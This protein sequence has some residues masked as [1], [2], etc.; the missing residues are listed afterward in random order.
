MDLLIQ[1]N[2]NIDKNYLDQLDRMESMPLS[3]ELFKNTST[4]YDIPIKA[5]IYRNNNGTGNISMGQVYQLVNYLNDIF[6]RNTNISFYLL[7]D[8]GLVNNSNYANNGEQYFNEYITNNRVPGA[9]NVHFVINSSWKGRGTWPWDDPNFA[10][11]VQTEYSFLGLTNLVQIANTTAHEIG[12]TL[13]LYHTHHPGRRENKFDLNEQCGD[14]YQ[15]AV[16]RSKRQGVACVSTFDKKKCEV[17]GDFLC[18]TAADPGL[19]YPLRVPAS[20]VLSGCD[21]D[22][23]SAGTDNW[24]D[25]W[26]P[27]VENIMDYAPYSCRSVFSP[28]QVAKMYGYIGDIGISYPALNISGPNSLCSGNIATY[29]VPYQSGV[30]FF[31]EMPYNMNLLDGQGTNTDI[32]DPP[33]DGYD[34][35]CPLYTYTYSTPYIG[36]ADYEWSV[37]NGYI[38]SGQYT[39]QVQIALTQSPSQ[40][41]II[42]LELT[43]VCDSSLFGQKIVTHGDP[44][45]PAQQCFSH[46]DKNGESLENQESFISD[47]DILLYPN[48]ASTAID[49]IIPKEEKYNVVLLDIAG[50]KIYESDKDMQRHFRLDVQAYPEG[51]YIIH[52]MGK[53]QT[54]S[55]RL[56][57]KR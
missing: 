38:V 9:I 48:P 31:W 33:I 17:N 27:T 4:I 23:V 24:G 37:T 12:H 29:S 16:S 19:Y 43:N 2:V 53:Y 11:A 1:N 22:N 35:A 25:T 32:Q 55:K 15:E 34:Q 6:E 56:I 51:I 47:R 30:T 49:I 50:R 42:D 39:N 44:P 7:C 54:F 45:F 36:N 8:I 10:F 21:F 40:Q 3:L 57:L 28:L 46:Q 26:A 5:W 13:G 20:Y 18:D 14:C 41:T 52:L